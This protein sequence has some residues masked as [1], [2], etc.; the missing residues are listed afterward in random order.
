[1]SEPDDQSD[2]PVGRC[3][4]TVGS[5]PCPRD[6]LPGAA[7]CREHLGYRHA[8]DW[9]GL[10]DA[11]SRELRGTTLSD[12]E[13]RLLADRCA[14]ISADAYGDEFL[15][16]HDLLTR[17]GVRRD[18]A[19]GRHLP[20]HERIRLLTEPSA[21]AA[22]GGSRPEP[23]AGNAPGPHGESNAETP[24]TDSYA[25]PVTEPR[26]DVSHEPP[27]TVLRPRPRLGPVPRV[28]TMLKLG[29]GLLVCCFSIAGGAAL[30]G[31]Y[32]AR[33]ADQFVGRFGR[34]WQQRVRGIK[35]VHFYG[36]R[37]ETTPLEWLYFPPQATKMHEL[38]Q[39]CAQPSPDL[40]PSICDTSGQALVTSTGPNG[41][42]TRVDDTR[43]RHWFETNACPLLARL[44]SVNYSALPD[45]GWSRY[46]DHGCAPAWT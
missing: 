5:E 8:S 1:M 45:H 42:V 46:V 2:V 20:L 39:S 21:N 29:I 12:R 17:L 44:D 41:A 33:G 24:S 30:Y 34:A 4:A 14:R 10:Y 40:T 15:L 28:M 6:A 23:S 16:N 11:I 25:A 37:W 43:L 38:F 19:D 22:S 31:Q 35:L 7:L 27:L 32:D 9:A 3:R 36:N 13:I 26:L 18:D